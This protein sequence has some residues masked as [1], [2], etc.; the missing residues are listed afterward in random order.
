MFRPR[1]CCRRSRPAHQL[2]PE[3]VL[4]PREGAPQGRRVVGTSSPEAVG[5]DMERAFIEFA[6]VATLIVATIPAHRDYDSG[7]N[8]ERRAKLTANGQALLQNLRKLKTA[9]VERHKRYTR[10]GAVNA[11]AVAAFGAIAQAQ[12]GV[13][14]FS[15]SIVRALHPFDNSTATRFPPSHILPLLQSAAL[16]PHPHLP[17]PILFSFAPRVLSF[18]TLTSLSEVRNDS[19]SPPRARSHKRSTPPCRKRRPTSSNDGAHSG[20][21]RPRRMPRWRLRDRRRQRIMGKGAAS[22]GAARRQR[23]GRMRLARGLRTEDRKY[24]CME[25]Q[26]QRTALEDRNRS[27]CDSRPAG[28]R[29]PRPRFR[30]CDTRCVDVRRTAADGTRPRVFRAFQFWGRRVHVPKQREVSF[31]QPAHETSTNVNT[32]LA[33]APSYAPSYSSHSNTSSPASYAGPSANSNYGGSSAP[34]SN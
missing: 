6:R 5:L 8:V 32:N 17:V 11:Q 26:S 19:S 30:A 27:R 7:L 10:S 4:V 24:L 34:L 33:P 22:M 1:G 3:A 14:L 16:C 13:S 21:R 28:C 31:P 18:P 15:S 29:R 20:R 12:A 23:L 9:L 2:R 25:G